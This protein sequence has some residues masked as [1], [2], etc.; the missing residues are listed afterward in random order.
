MTV[1][2][3]ELQEGADVQ[4][5]IIVNVTE[6]PGTDEMLFVHVHS[7]CVCCIIGTRGVLLL[8]SFDESVI[9]QSHFTGE[10]L[11]IMGC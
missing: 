8:V 1:L 5:V 11:T 10:R 2:R 9:F 6:P 4:V 7:V 3:E